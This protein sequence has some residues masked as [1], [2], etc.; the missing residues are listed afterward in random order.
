MS[1]TP[2]VLASTSPRRQ[3]FLL[4]LGLQFSV[5]AANIDET[6]NAGEL[7]LALAQ[8]LAASKARAVR[9]ALA[10]PALIIAA[11]TVV[12]LDAAI[13]GKP[14]D[15]ADARSMLSALRGRDHHVMSAVSVLDNRTGMQRSVVNDTR[16][17]M[18]SYTN[19]E[20]DAYIATGDPFDKAGGYAIQHAGFHPVTALDGCFAG[21]M[22][23]PLADLST[24]LAGFG[25]VLTTAL[26]P[27]SRDAG[28]VDVLCGN[29]RWGCIDGGL[30]VWGTG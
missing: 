16:V 22:G 26:P 25:V 3:A 6:P 1:S 20:I 11:D 24:L 14:R 29:G 7:P 2:L 9:D 17:T 12:A 19:D 28:C 5:V 10:A 21:V 27:I 13:M 15:A 4:A 23:L 8:R 30:V 18:R